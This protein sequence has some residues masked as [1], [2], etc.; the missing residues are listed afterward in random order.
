MA[1]LASARSQLLTGL[2]A[3]GYAL[4][5]AVLL[6][7]NLYLGAL[8]ALAPALAL[9]VL[10]AHS[11]S[12]ATLR[13][14]AAAAWL[15]LLAAASPWQTLSVTS[16][17][18]VSAGS[19]A[20]AAKFLITAL[21]FA[22]ALIVRAPR[23]RYTWPVKALLTYAAIAALGGLAGADPGS[24]VVRAIRLAA[25][26]I[27]VVWLSGRLERPRLATLFTGFCAGVSLIALAARAGGLSGSRLYGSR[28]DGYLP[29]LHPNA[30]GFLAAAALLCAAALLARGEMRP[31]VFVLLAPLLVLTLALT[32]SRTSMIG[33][34]VGLLALAGPRLAARGPVIVGLLAVALLAGAFLQTNTESRPLSGLLTHNGSTTTTATLGSRV[35]EWESV[36]RLNDSAASV[37]VGQG[38]AAKSVAVNL[39]SAQYAPVDGTWPAAYLSAGLVGL[40]T[41]AA[42]VLVT[43][44]AAIRRRDDLAIA[45]VV[46]LIVSSLTTDIFNDVTIALLLMLATTAVEFARPVAL[47]RPTPTPGPTRELRPAAA[48]ERAQA[49]GHARV[50]A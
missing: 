37:A 19:E 33:L 34:V 42:A 6:V 2:A 7:H 46:F 26:V 45:I 28:L 9:A 11:G 50:W 15:L 27:A 17:G 39:V 31:R 4:A 23:V 20:D 25:V 3:L 47:A 48:P 5:C 12:V 21:A 16:D 13:S 35:S 18:A 24:S 36:L 40:L 30:L 29:P 38:L 1:S 49:R 10:M 44:R 14:R 41:L 22:L 43:L 32:E 8:A